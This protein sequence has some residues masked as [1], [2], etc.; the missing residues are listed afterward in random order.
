MLLKQNTAQLTTPICLI[1]L[2]EKGTPNAKVIMGECCRISLSIWCLVVNTKVKTW[3]G[4]EFCCSCDPQSLVNVH[5]IPYTKLYKN[6]N[7]IFSAPKVCKQSWQFLCSSCWHCIE[8]SVE[9]N[10]RFCVDKMF[11]ALTIARHVAGSPV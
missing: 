11:I 10:A 3:C 7:L 6:V 4:K 2:V 5:H 9:F 8:F 1:A